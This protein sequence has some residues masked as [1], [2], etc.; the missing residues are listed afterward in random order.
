MTVGIWIGE[1]EEPAFA[2]DAGVAGWVCAN[3]VPVAAIE[4][5]MHATSILCL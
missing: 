1:L 4:A 2:G 3:A 5:A